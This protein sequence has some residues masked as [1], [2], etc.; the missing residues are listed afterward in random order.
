M[1]C[2]AGLSA[3]DGLGDEDEDEGS[4]GGDSQIDR[5]ISKIYLVGPATSD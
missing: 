3:Y 4:T 5:T 1:A 2:R